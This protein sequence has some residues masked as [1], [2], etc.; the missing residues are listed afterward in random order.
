MK[1][2]NR[3]ARV[4]WG[5]LGT[6]Q[7]ARKNWKAILN[8][9]NAVVSAVASRD[10]HRGRKFVSECQRAAPFGVEPRVL[11]SYEDLIAS[12]EI[13]AVYIPL[14]T[15]IRKEW[16]LRA[17]EARKHVLCEKPCG[18]SASDVREMIDACRRSRV[19]FM[20]GVMF[21]HS[22]RL[23]S[24]RSVLDDGASVGRVKRVT[25]SF[26]ANIP[27]AVLRGNIR[28]RGQLEPLGCL[29]DLGWY[30]IRLSLWAMNW[31][32]PRQVLARS[33]SLSGEAR[34]LGTVPTEFSA[35]LL[36]EG[37]ASAA[38]YCSFVT[39]DEQWANICGE[40]GSL[41]VPDFVLPFQGHRP[42]YETNQTTYDVHGCDFNMQPHRRRFFV[43]EQSNSHPSA[44]ETK[45]FR[46]F[47][48]HVLS[49]SPDDSWADIALKTQEVVDT[50]LEAAHTTTARQL[51]EGT[52]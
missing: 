45:M 26:C 1:K 28:G 6:A 47:S 23:A 29:G 22:C 40:K 17:A 20:D 9:G 36:F 34:I 48:D 8:T 2:T 25:S 44:Q 14:P 38:F 16:V 35:E 51:R 7:I 15:G 11:G 52:C 30:C 27:R 50:C 12:P 31:A 3:P 43:S 4:R 13:D 32:L 24:M 46:T 37:G 5:I 10:L 41:Y 21:M 33:I 18:C 42:S 39:A 19:Q 49:S